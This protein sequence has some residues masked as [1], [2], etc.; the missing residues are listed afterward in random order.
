LTA[1]LLTAGLLSAQSNPS[2]WKYVPPESDSLVGIRWETLQMSAFAHSVEAELSSTGSLGFPDLPILRETKQFVIGGPSRLAVANGAFSLEKLRAQAA[3][4]DFHR[5]RFLNAELW[6]AP[7]PDAGN[8]DVSSVAY[9]T[10]R[11][12]LVGPVKAVEAAIARVSDPKNRSYSP[13]MARGA[14]YAEEDLWVVAAK[15]PDPLASLFLPL[16]LE[17]TAFEGSV[18]AW[19][20]LHLVAAI[21]RKTPTDALDFADWLSESLASRPAMAE[22]T[23]IVTR[24][25]S[26][27]LRME[28]S[29]EL[30]NSSLRQPEDAPVAVTATK[31]QAREFVA[32]A[33]AA[34]APRVIA[35]TLTEASA[36]SSIPHPPLLNALAPLT[37]MPIDLPP[38]PPRTIRILGL[39]GGPREILLPGR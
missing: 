6:I 12:L 39:D 31:A 9:I 30:L 11:L 28:L 23:E 36:T 3:A 13:L 15:L 38:P 20:G 26:V 25:R 17:A 24:D 32:P 37:A 33:K 19:D 16:D 18:S 14:R 10:E 1:G 8:P 5:R 22:G 7:A 4:K 35:I 34:P 29:E 21:E 27:L 2:W